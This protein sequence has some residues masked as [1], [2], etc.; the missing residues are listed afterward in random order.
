MAEH[1]A[2]S[3]ANILSRDTAAEMSVPVVHAFV[4]LRQLM[5]NHRA[6]A[7][8]ERRRS[9]LFSTPFDPSRFVT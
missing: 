7:A 6:L 5:A 3:T 2:F 9:M 1:G 4:R 8:S